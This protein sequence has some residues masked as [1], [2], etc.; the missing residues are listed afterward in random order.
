MLNFDTTHKLQANYL[1]KSL[2][3]LRTHNTT[4][5]IHN[6]R[7]PPDFIIDAKPEEQCRICFQQ[8]SKA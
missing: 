7:V 6:M 8:T 2:E 5:F 1:G 3:P 4:A